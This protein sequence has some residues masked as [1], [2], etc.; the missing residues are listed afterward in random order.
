MIKLNPPSNFPLFSGSENGAD[1]SKSLYEPCGRPFAWLALAKE[2]KT[3]ARMFFHG[4]GADLNFLSWL[5]SM[6]VSM[7][8]TV[9]CRLV[10]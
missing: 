5:L 2:K 7:H 4:D 10:A 8:F 3:C 9:C 6:V 1:A